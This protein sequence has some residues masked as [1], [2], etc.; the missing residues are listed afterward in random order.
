MA[1]PL[2]TDVTAKARALLNDK[3]TTGGA[4]Y[5]DAFLQDYVQIAQDTLVNALIARSVERMK[6]RSQFTVP[7]GTVTLDYAMNTPGLLPVGWPVQYLLP[8]E[9]ISGDQFWEA[10][11]GGNN[12]DF[13]PMSG[14]NEIP[15]TQISSTLQFWNQVG[16]VVQLLGCTQDRDVRMDYWAGLG[17]VDPAGR[18]LIVNSG[19]ALAALVAG[20]A[21]GAR[22]QDAL[23]ARFCQFR[24]DGMIGGLAGFEIES[25]V[26]ADI[27]AQQS[28]PV[29]R[30]PYF[31][32]DRYTNL[33]TNRWRN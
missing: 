9:Y 13:I 30:R 18:M 20:Y 6:F 16:G 26:T 2:Y 10:K 31:G 25:I 24:D 3:G 29:R 27:K 21:A 12:E 33:N 23:A 32:R 5:Q 1:A 8:N 15:R 4:T 7:A 14:P 17:N 19:N 22:G 11:V 28:E